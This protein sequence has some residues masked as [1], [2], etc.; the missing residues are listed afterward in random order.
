[1]YKCRRIQYKCGTTGE[2][3]KCTSKTDYINTEISIFGTISVMYFSI[4]GLLARNIR[5]AASK[6]L[7][8]YT[9]KQITYIDTNWEH[10]ISSE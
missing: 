1:M 6:I 8:L 2:P 4:F 5:L 10:G 9:V 3:N 7:A